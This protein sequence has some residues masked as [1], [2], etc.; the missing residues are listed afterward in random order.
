MSN[1]F[2]LILLRVEVPFEIWIVLVVCT[3][4]IYL[5]VF[6]F[7]R[8]PEAPVAQRAELELGALL[9]DITTAV[10]GGREEEILK[11]V[12]SRY[13]VQ[14]ERKAWLVGITKLGL[15]EVLSSDEISVGSLEDAK[16][17]LVAGGMPQDFAE[18]LVGAIIRSLIAMQSGRTDEKTPSPEAF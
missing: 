1:P 17:R 5:I 15:N 2:L 6:L 7:R 18:Q 10:M 4:G 8:E 12:W 13:P 14:E 3:G 16:K 9:G 11:L